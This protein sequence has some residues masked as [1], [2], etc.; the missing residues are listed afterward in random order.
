MDK[1]NHFNVSIA[2]SIFRVGAGVTLMNGMLITAGLLLII[3]EVLGVAEE[4]V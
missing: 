2:K 4:M 3:A 1:L